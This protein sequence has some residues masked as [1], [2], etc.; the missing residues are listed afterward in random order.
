MLLVERGDMSMRVPSLPT[1]LR[2]S[3]LASQ[4]LKRAARSVQ[5]PKGQQAYVRGRDVEYHVAGGRQKV[6][7]AHV[8]SLHHAAAPFAAEIE[9]GERRRF[10]SGPRS[11]SLYVILYVQAESHKKGV[12]G[13]SG[14]AAATN[15]A[16]PTEPRAKRAR[17]C[18][19][20]TDS[21]PSSAYRSRAT[22]RRCMVGSS[23]RVEDVGTSARPSST[24]SSR[25]PKP[26]MR[27]TRPQPPSGAGRIRLSRGPSESTWRNPKRRPHRQPPFDDHALVV[28]GQTYRPSHGSCRHVERLLL[29]LLLVLLLLARP[30]RA[31][32]SEIPLIRPLWPSNRK[33][34][35]G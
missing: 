19:S 17:H 14:E 6:S 33:S 5:V 4:A 23:V 27:R 8:R 29:L 13:A 18:S 11:L 16:G 32:G 10:A 26:P 24:Q 22:S 25:S 2:E 3:E 12:A 21:G 7:T 20:L 9:I 1:T 28:V 34:G 31:I 30:V 15:A 35:G